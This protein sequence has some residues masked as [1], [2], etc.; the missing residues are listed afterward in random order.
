[1]IWVEVGPGI[2]KKWDVK[3]DEGGR[4]LCRYLLCLALFVSAN[5]QRLRPQMPGL[6]GPTS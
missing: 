1:V 6:A 2:G 4:R 5:K 3:H